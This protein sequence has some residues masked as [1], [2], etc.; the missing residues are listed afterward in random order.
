M[1]IAEGEGRVTL[2]GFMAE[3]PR[4]LAILYS[5]GAGIRIISSLLWMGVGTRCQKMIQNVGLVDC[6]LGDLG[7]ALLN[8]GVVMVEV[9]RRSLPVPAQ[10]DS[11]TQ[12]LV[13][14]C[15]FVTHPLTASPHLRKGV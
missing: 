1:I 3:L 11:L 4:I 10:A 5:H 13:L 7:G 12:S 15:P 8:C 14:K 9:P 6:G 2:V